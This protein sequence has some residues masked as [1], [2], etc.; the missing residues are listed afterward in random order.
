MTVYAWPSTWVPSAFELRILPNTR[1]FVGA[2]T[3]VVQVIDLLGERWQ[4]R[5]DLPPTN[6]LDE[7]GAREAWFD[8]L[9]G[10][11]NQFSLWNFR[12]P[13]PRGTARGTLTLAASALQGTNS[14]S[15]A[16]CRPANNL[17]LG[18]GFEV[19][20][21]TDGLADGWALYTS[22]TTG[23]T[24]KAL[25][26]GPLMA[27]AVGALYQVVQSAALNG[28]VGITSGASIAVT[29][30]LP[31][32]L[33][34][35][36]SGTP[37]TTVSLSINWLNSSSAYISDAT[38]T[39]SPTLGR[40]S[41]VGTAPVGATYALIYC[42]IQSSAGTGALINIDN[43]QFEQAAAASPNAGPATLN[44]GDM[45][46]VNGQLVR[47][48]VD[49]TASDMGVAALE[50]QP[51][52][53]AAQSSGAAVTWNQPTCNVMLKTADGVPTTYRPGFVEGLSLEFVEVP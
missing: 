1:T 8:R 19:D 16:G 45:I 34:A 46:G 49:A 22:G 50:I 32:A 6:S 42:F 47:V 43:L 38:A 13:V 5:I 53:R 39:A 25:A 23:T 11:A 14:I 7:A 24:S 48:M 3:P 51:R 30:G 41:V 52:L 31:Y 2:Y 27:G 20:S 17:L 33:S 4:G 44:A 21:N 9:K 18:G 10:Q 37:G 40:R 12:R 26:A 15:V 29:A 28:A 35:D 36:L